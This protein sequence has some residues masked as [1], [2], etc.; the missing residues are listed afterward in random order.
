MDHQE[1]VKLLLHT[2][3][4]YM[5]GIVLTYISSHHNQS[6]KANHSSDV[7]VRPVNPTRSNMVRW[8]CF[9]H[10]TSIVS[11]NMSRYANG[12]HNFLL[13][14]DIR[15]C[16][17]VEKGPMIITVTIGKRNGVPFKQEQAATYTA[18]PGSNPKS[19]HSTYVF[20]NLYSWNWNCNWYRMR[21]GWK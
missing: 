21:K 19:K 16:P 10:K 18:A 1:K 12:C 14:L 3:L 15:K 9:S 8:L 5:V 6:R 13:K 4:P 2:L 20:L 11:H 17:L 7:T